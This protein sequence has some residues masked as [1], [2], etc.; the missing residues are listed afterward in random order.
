M[1][2]RHRPWAMLLALLAVFSLVAAACGDDSS[3]DEPAGSGDGTTT[4][5]PADGGDDNEGDEGASTADLVLGGP[6]DCPTNPYCIPG[7][8]DVYGV[9]LSSGFVPLDGGGPLTVTALREG[10]IDIAVLFSTNAVIAEEGWVV[11]DD[12]E[13]LINADNVVP[14][15]STELTDAYGDGFTALVNAVS[16]ALDTEQLTELNRQ[17]EIELID[18][19]EVAQAWLDDNDLLDGNGEPSGDGPTIVIGAQDFGESEVLSQVYG[20]ALEAGG[21]SVE[22]QALGGYREIVFASF[23]SGDINF[24]LEY[25]ASALEFLNEA[26]GEATGDAD[27]TVGLLQGYL[28]E[29][30]LVAL[31]PSPAVD[32]NSFVVTQETADRYGLTSLADLAG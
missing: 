28:D 16:Q 18:A 3:D 1:N 22:Y 27:E 5:A 9:D 29:L 10:E 4:T 26:A 13:G 32:S 14:V 7:L 8:D 25:A 31:D 12:P 6:Q 24:T 19:D 21:Y 20:Q 2:L 11:L 17:F 23:E 30:G 15:M